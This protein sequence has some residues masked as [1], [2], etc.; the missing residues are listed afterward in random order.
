MS[1]NITSRSLSVL[2]LL[3]SFGIQAEQQSAPPVPTE[4]RIINFYQEELRLPAAVDEAV[5]L[6]HWNSER[7]TVAMYK[8]AKGKGPDYPIK[9]DINVGKDEIAVML[10]GTCDFTA[11]ESFRRTLVPGDIMMIP[12]GLEHGG[13]CGADG[14]EV[15]ML[16]F[17]VPIEARF[18][19]E[20]SAGRDKMKKLHEKK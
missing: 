2:L 19:E 11:G 3:I 17:Y 13:V 7:M 6:N 8:M 15:L 12:E 5:Y 9:P 14:S 16:V 10:K 4:P 18:G 20:G 1:S